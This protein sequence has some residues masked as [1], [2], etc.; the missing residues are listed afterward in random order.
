MDLKADHCRRLTAALLFLAAASPGPALA[1]SRP[2]EAV[3]GAGFVHVDQLFG[4]GDPTGQAGDH[5]GNAVAVS[6]DTVVV[7][8]PTDDNAGGVDA[9]SAYV[10]VR[11]ANSYTLQQKLFASDAAPNA[12][13]GASVAVFGNTVVVGTS[14]ADT[15]GGADAGAA[16]VFVR[17]GTVWA[18]QQKLV[19]ADGAAGDQLGTS[20]SVS[21][22]TALVGSPLDDTPGGVDAGSAYVFLRSGTT[23]TQQQKLTASDAGNNDQ[24]GSSVSLSLN[25]AVLGAPFDNNGG[26]SDAGSAYVFVRAGTTWTEQQKLT[27]SDGAA[28]DEFGASVSISSDVALV[29]SP[30]AATSG[31][32]D[33]GA[34]YPYFRSGTTWTEQAKLLAPGGAPGDA[35]GFSVS[36]DGVLGAGGA[37]LTDPVGGPDSGAV[38]VYRAYVSTDLSVT[39][40]DNQTTAAPGETLTYTIVVHNSGPEAATAASVVDN[41]PAV[42]LAPSWTCTATA[43]SSCTA[44]GSG[45]INDAANLLVGGSATY[46]L[47]ATLDQ[48]A[49]GTVSNTASVTPALVGVDPTPADASATDTDSIAPESDLTIAKSDAPDPAPPAGALVYTLTV[50]NAGP[51]NATGVVVTDTLPAGVTFVSSTPGAPTCT[52]GGST[53]TCTLGALAGA[54]SA[55]VTINTTVA[56]TAGIVVNSAAV[57]A[58]EP[59][60][61][62]GNNTATASTAIGA[63]ADAELSHGMNEVFDLAALPGPVADQDVYRMSQKPYASYEVVIDEASGDI[64]GPAGPILERLGGDG[65]TVVQGSAAVGAGFSRSLRWGNFTASEVEDEVIRVRS[66]GCS[67]DCG[68]DDIYRLRVYETSYAIPRF[69]NSGSQITVLVLQNPTNYTIAGNAYF[70]ATSGALVG[71]H[72]FTLAP[73]GALVLNTAT[74]PGAGGISGGILIAHDGRYGDLAGKAV[75]LEPA[76]GFSFDSA[77]DVRAR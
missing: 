36:V 47:T 33:T 2:R 4:Q 71:T 58:A 57:A 3:L 15:A 14:L 64:S 44:S 51:S 50:T 45:N 16:Y 56:A 37:P 20:V 1:D 18:E 11:S 60:P 77:L 31:G 76:T 66:A 29:G 34:I 53:L 28:L 10:F 43:G 52:L 75:A 72:A 13:F 27:A 46:L 24:L 30:R 48:A 74:V 9:G 19:A 67:T 63:R 62:P 69:N 65:T 17:S 35:F 23:W 21:T 6:G 5:F 41:L 12:H 39:K 7:G 26:G 70:R 49:T 68:P 40:T 8:S 22:D 73:K 38:N 42:L 32:P 25:T 61:F 55:T 54:T 59:D